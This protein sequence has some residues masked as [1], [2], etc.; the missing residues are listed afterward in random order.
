MCGMQQKI[1]D[2]NDKSITEL[3]LDMFPVGDGIQYHEFICEDIV[4]FY[5]NDEDMIKIAFEL[6]SLPWVEIPWFKIMKINTDGW[7]VISFLNKISF[8]HVFPSLLNELSTNKN[9]LT[10]IF[11]ENHLNLSNVYRNWELEYY[12]SLDDNTIKIINRILEKINTP[13]SKDAIGI[14]WH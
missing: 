3:L 2:Y 14:Y 11:I 7:M 4:R 6:I 1:V 10:D 8:I 5:E 13:L 12:L 9:L